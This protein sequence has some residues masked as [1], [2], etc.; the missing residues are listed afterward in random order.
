MPCLVEGEIR[1]RLGESRI[2]TGTNNSVQV[3]RKGYFSPVTDGWAANL[4]RKTSLGRTQGF[5]DFRDAKGGDF[6]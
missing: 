5:L 2:R 3:R 4:I 6:F 1:Q